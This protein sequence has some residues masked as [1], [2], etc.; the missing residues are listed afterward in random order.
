MLILI[1]NNRWLTTWSKLTAPSGNDYLIGI[2]VSRKG[3]GRSFLRTKHRP[4]HHFRQLLF[5]P[6]TGKHLLKLGVKLKT[7]FRPMRIKL[8]NIIRGR[9]WGGK[10]NAELYDI[11]KGLKWAYKFKAVNQLLGMPN[12][13]WCT[14]SN[15]CEVACSGCVGA[16]VHFD[17]TSAEGK[18][19]LV[20]VDA[21]S[22]WIEATTMTSTSTTSTLKALFQWLSRFGF[23]R[24]PYF[25]GGS[26]F[27]SQEFS[28]N[29]G[30]EYLSDC[31]MG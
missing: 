10:W 11:I 19:L 26:Q 23:L 18:C 15:L 30:L 12:S 4:C 31:G 22:K 17:Y 2:L 28:K 9:R 8:W 1:F 21:W 24:F 14:S 27:V 6:E 13:R 7:R 20:L 25:V 29:G 3:I 16:Y 5:F